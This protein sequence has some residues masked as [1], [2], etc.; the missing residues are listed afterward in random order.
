MTKNNFKD[1]VTFVT[2]SFL[3]D[4]NLD[5]SFLKD[6]PT[7]YESI[8]KRA[9]AHEKVLKAIESANKVALGTN[10]NE[11]IIPGYMHLPNVPSPN[12]NMPPDGGTTPA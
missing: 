4:K 10:E 3:A 8:Q 7:V 9:A 2:N 12:K 6:N 1:L 5:F 11:P